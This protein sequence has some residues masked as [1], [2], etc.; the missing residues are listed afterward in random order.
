MI[1]LGI[2]ESESG[3]S[4]LTQQNSAPCFFGQGAGQRVAIREPSEALLQ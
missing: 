4:A 2:N 1:L 3:R